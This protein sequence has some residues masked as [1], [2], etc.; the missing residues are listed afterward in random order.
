MI[1]LPHGGPYGVRDGWG[2][3]WEAQLLASRGYS[4][5]Q[6]NFRGSDGYG[7]DFQTAGFREWGGLMQDD[8]TDATHW[9]IERKFAQ[10][11][12]I[13][14]YGGSYGGYAA[15]MGA[16]KEPK[17]YRCAIGVDGVYDLE[18]VLS[19]A[20]VPTSRTGRTYLADVLGGDIADLR[21]RSPAYNAQKIEIPV[22]LVHGKEDQRADYEQARRMK[23]ALE[24]NRKKVEW[25]ALS[26][27]GHSIYDEETRREVY[28]RILK[29]LDANLMK[30]PGEAT[31]ALR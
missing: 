1:L 11:D 29:F 6:I 3:D 16:V 7:I 17:L 2:F 12:R 9:A 13:C 23:R 8:L 30:P 26:R 19:S 31:Q 5:L 22:L 24:K 15:L 25:M 18:L 4:V 10:Q 27:E 14:I 20:D 28:E 21:S